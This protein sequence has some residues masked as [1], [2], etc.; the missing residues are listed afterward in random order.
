MEPS[1]EVNFALDFLMKLLKTKL[2]DVKALEV[3]CGS[4]YTILLREYAGHWFPANANIGSAYRSIHTQV[5]FMDPRIREACSYSGLAE[6]IV[7]NAL[8]M[9][10]TIWIDPR[11]VSYRFGRDGSICDNAVH[12]SNVP[13]DPGRPLIMRSSRESPQGS[14]QSSPNTQR[15]DKSSPRSTRK[16]PKP[17][18]LQRFTPTAPGNLISASAQPFYRSVPV[19]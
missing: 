16:H 18:V 4:L 7:A 11:E 14:P 19:C 5:D 17:L 3:F 1:C 12:A 6:N 9:V 8:P 13:M 2:K 10:L 15:K